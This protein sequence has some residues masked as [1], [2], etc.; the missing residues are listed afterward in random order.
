MKNRFQL[1][2]LVIL[3]VLFISVNFSFATS[4]VEEKVESSYAVAFKT[5]LS[6]DVNSFVYN[7]CLWTNQCDGY[8]AS[9]LQFSEKIIRSFKIDSGVY[10]ASA[11]DAVT[12]NDKYLVSLLHKNRKIPS[13]D[14]LAIRLKAYQLVINPYVADVCGEDKPIFKSVT[15]LFKLTGGDYMR[16]I[17]ILVESEEEDYSQIIKYQ[18]GGL[19]KLVVDSDKLVRVGTYVRFKSINERDRELNGVGRA[20]TARDTSDRTPKLRSYRKQKHW[21]KD[22]LTN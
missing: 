22:N 18:N 21:K 14:K 6:S 4:L 13:Q 9:N 7:L 8:R 1:K 15:P 19:K 10:A 20:L 11:I 3:K 2:S 12:K 17:G 5:V 16:L